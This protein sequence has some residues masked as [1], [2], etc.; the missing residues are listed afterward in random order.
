LVAHNLKTGWG[1]R[2]YINIEGNSCSKENIKVTSFLA[3]HTTH[4]TTEAIALIIK[5]EQ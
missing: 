1:K 3:L 5:K 4:K 2:N